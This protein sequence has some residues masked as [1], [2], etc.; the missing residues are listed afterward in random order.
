MRP[1]RGETA[2]AVWSIPVD[3]EAK[4]I[5]ADRRFSRFGPGNTCPG[6]LTGHPLSDA[7]LVLQ[8]LGR[9]LHL[10]SVPRLPVVGFGQPRHPGV[11]AGGDQLDRAMLRARSGRTGPGTASLRRLTESFFTHEHRSP[12]RGRK[13]GGP[14]INGTADYQTQGGNAERDPEPGTP[15]RNLPVMV[16]I[17][18]SASAWHRGRTGCSSHRHG[19]CSRGRSGGHGTGR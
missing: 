6:W 12:S 14:K 15:S 19:C 2:P 17:R 4:P 13:T 5:Q 11:P 8:V 1:P 3:F 10:V 16:V 18:L 7:A 9:G